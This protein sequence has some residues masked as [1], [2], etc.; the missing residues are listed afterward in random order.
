V[1]TFDVFFE[2]EVLR[3]SYVQKPGSFP[4]GPVL[5]I[6]KEHSHVDP[7]I[8]WVPVK[9]RLD[10]KLRQDSGLKKFEKEILTSIAQIDQLEQKILHE[11][12]LN[13]IESATLDC[14]SKDFVFEALA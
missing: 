4:V 6:A 13:L 11:L 10:G 1:C 7:V 5:L 12:L 9:R 8:Q 3:K 2:V 14:V